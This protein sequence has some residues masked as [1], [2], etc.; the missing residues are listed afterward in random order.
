M[1]SHGFAFLCTVCICPRVNVSRT[2]CVMIRRSLHIA[3]EDYRTQADAMYMYMSINLCTWTVWSC[4]V[5]F[6][7]YRAMFVS[8]PLKSK[9]T[10]QSFALRSAALVWQS[11]RDTYVDVTFTYSITSLSQGREKQNICTTVALIRTWI[12]SALNAILICANMFV[13][14][15]TGFC[16]YENSTVERVNTR[17][18]CVNDSS[19]CVYNLH[20]L[21]SWIT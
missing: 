3:S 18:V 10:S 13:G 17:H 7:T 2:R 12:G 8:L 19:I 5:I 6:C 16:M 20:S 11:T 15:Y 1:L 21:F 14:T 9:V 4:Q